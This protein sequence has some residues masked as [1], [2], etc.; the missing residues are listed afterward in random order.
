LGRGGARSVEKVCYKSSDE[1]DGITSC[2]TD[3]AVTSLF[4]MFKLNKSLI[5][6]NLFIHRPLEYI[7]LLNSSPSYSPPLKV[8]VRR[9]P[10]PT[11]LSM[12]IP[13]PESEN[14]PSPLIWPPV[15]APLGPLLGLAL[16]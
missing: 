6:H 2:P 16:G 7:T 5:S 12:F 11:V 3:G 15:G 4:Q 1:R 14:D 8:S 13:L 9:P 10:F